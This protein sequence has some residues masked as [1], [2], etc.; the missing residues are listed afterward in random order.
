M[1]RCRT[2][3]QELATHEAGHLLAIAI[4]S[5]LEPG[6]FEWRRLAAYE[7][8]HVEPRPSRS[9]DWETPSDRNLLIVRRAVVALAG[10]AAVAACLA[11]EPSGD[12][13]TLDVIYQTLGRVDFEL[14]H[15]WLTLQ[16]YDPEQGALELEI[17]RLFREIATVFMTAPRRKALTQISGRILAHLEAA[18]AACLDAISV[19]ALDLLDGVMLGGSHE[20]H[21]RETLA[22][23]RTS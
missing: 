1:K 10:G 6:P 18:D 21:L 8:A 23:E 11:P 12:G 4:L 5:D 16:R 14:A 7:I 13:A 15:E 19:P 2:A 17:R 3:R 22:V 9:F 20:F